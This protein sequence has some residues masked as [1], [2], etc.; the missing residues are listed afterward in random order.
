MIGGMLLL[1]VTGCSDEEVAIKNVTEE[2]KYF[3]VPRRIVFVNGITDEYL[4]EVEGYCTVNGDEF[5]GNVGNVIAIT[6]KLGDGS[7]KRHFMGL[8]NNVTFVAEQLEGSHVSRDHYKVNF[9]PKAILPDI[10]IK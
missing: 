2:A 1:G 10:S 4:L 5:R 6:C 9:K 3:N 7:I 8:S